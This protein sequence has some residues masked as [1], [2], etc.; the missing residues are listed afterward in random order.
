MGVFISIS[1][2]SSVAIDVA[3]SAKSPL[4]LLDYSH[5]YMVL[6]GVSTIKEVI[7]RVRRHSSQMGRAYLPVAEFGG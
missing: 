6:N 3:S 4:L 7:Q 5:L 2:Y 1:G